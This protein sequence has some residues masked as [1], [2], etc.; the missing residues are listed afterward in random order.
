M[1]QFAATGYDPEW[2]QLQAEVVTPRPEQLIR[3]V[4]ASPGDPAEVIL[5]CW[6]WAS[7]RQ[8]FGG[9]IDVALHLGDLARLTKKPPADAFF[10]S[11]DRM[12]ELAAGKEIIIKFRSLSG[13]CINWGSATV[14]VNGKNFRKISGC[15]SLLITRHF[16]RRHI[17]ER[18]INYRVY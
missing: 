4:Y 16:L 12:L 18:I 8:L 5:L 15:S 17:V 11:P 7:R 10:D 6:D 9:Q 13:L 14:I 2:L 3:V 1:E